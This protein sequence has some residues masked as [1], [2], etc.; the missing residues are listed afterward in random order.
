MC[1]CVCL[2][3]FVCVCVHPDVGPIKPLDKFRVPKLLSRSDGVC[4]QSV[5]VN[6]E[7]SEFPFVRHATFSFF[8]SGHVERARLAHKPTGVW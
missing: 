7:M 2:R 6:M 1:V 4:A 5:L 8:S 3:V